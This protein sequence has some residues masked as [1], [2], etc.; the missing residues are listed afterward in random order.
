MSVST[1]ATADDFLLHAEKKLAETTLQEGGR[2]KT[3]R[4][5]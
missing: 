2:Q 4:V 1:V 5:L 3:I